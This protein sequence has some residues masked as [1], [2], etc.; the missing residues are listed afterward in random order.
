MWVSV[1]IVS[2]AFILQDEHDEFVRKNGKML[3]RAMVVSGQKLIEA[4]ENIVEE[5]RLKFVNL[6]LI[7]KLMKVTLERQ[8]S[9]QEH[10]KSRVGKTDRI[11]DQGFEKFFPGPF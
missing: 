5:M 1:F 7:Q 6:V 2:I 8:I 9:E 11:I 10:A 4:K 3:L